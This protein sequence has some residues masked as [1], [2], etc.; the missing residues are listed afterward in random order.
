[1]DK[2]DDGTVSFASLAT[3][4]QFTFYDPRACGQEFNR[5][6]GPFTKTAR[7]VY[8]FP[9][10]GGLCRMPHTDGTYRVHKLPPKTTS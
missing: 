8:T 10:A 3:G 2:L 6:Y 1:M 4:D 5:K 9:D 7:G